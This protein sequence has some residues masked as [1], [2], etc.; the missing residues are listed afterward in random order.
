MPT[1]VKIRT[2]SDM[3]ECE[4]SWCSLSSC[5]EHRC[6][7]C[8][9]CAAMPN[10]AL[11]LP[12]NGD[13]VNYKVCANWCAPNLHHCRRCDCQLCDF[14][15]TEDDGVAWLPYPPPSPRPKA[16]PP[17]SPRPSPPPPPA[18]SKPP[19]PS[20]PHPPPPPS[21]QPPNPPP[22]PSPPHPKP[23]PPP[24]PLPPPP[25]DAPPP[26]FTHPERL[27]PVAIGLL[28]LGGLFL[29]TALVQRC[30]GYCCSRGGR[31]VPNI[32]AASLLALVAS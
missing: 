30:V 14:C 4:A 2:A 1:S 3:G 5:R 9:V 23:P 27:V 19:P 6:H 11:S 21:P 25:P 16:P 15:A 18:P 28:G 20:P 13:P 10:Y 29:F 26:L 31:C 32:H 22:P 7:A 12:C 24:P 8:A 17:P